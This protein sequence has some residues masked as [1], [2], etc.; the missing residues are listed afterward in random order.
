MYKGQKFRPRPLSLAITIALGL[1]VVSTSTHAQEEIEEVT[2]TGSRIV[3]RDYQASSPIVTV[4]EDFFDQVSTVGVENALNQLPQFVPSQSMFSSQDVQPSAFNTPG[5]AT[6]N[7]RGLG[8]NRN[9]VLMDG[10]RA[11]PAN[12]QLVVDINTIPSAAIQSVEVISGGASSVYGADAMGG[13]T[14]FILKKNFE[15]F[16]LNLQTSATEQ[17]G[18]EET[19]VSALIGGSFGRSGNVML[20]INVSER[21][22]IFARDRDFYVE[23]WRDVN[24][25]GGEDIPFT[26]IEFTGNLPASS[27]YESIFG[28]GIAAPGEE[29]YINPDGTVFLNSASQGAVGYSGP[30]NDQ[31]KILGPGT[32]EPGALSANWL[33]QMLSTPLKRYSMFAR[34]NYDLNDNTNVFLQTNMTQT[35]VDTVLTFAPATSQWAANIP[36]DGRPVPP[37]L[38]ALLDSRPNPQGDYILSR[39]L[40]F[41]GPRRTSNNTDVYQ[42]L[43]GIEGGIGAS[44]WSYEAYISHGKTS[45]LTEMAGFPGLQNYRSVVEAPNWGQDLNLTVGA[46]LFFELKCTTGLPMV[47]YFEP[48][49]DCLDSIAGSMKHLTEMEQDIAEVNLTGELYELPAGVVGAAFGASYRENSYRWRPDD[50]LARPSTNYPIG[51][52]PTSYTQGKT[53]VKELY[54]ELLVPVL[55]GINGIEQLNLELGARYSDFNTAGEVW[56]YKGL[57]DWTINDVA[58][59]RGGFQRANRAPNVAELFTGAT[60]SVRGFAGADPCMANTNNTTWGNHPDNPNR[61][62]V[63][64]L[65]SE[66]INR[67]TG[68]NNE[69]PWHTAPNFPDAVVGPFPFNFPIELANITG[70]ANLENEEAD[71]LTLGVVLNSPFSGALETATLSIDWY[72]VEISNAIAP[73][74]AWS[75]Y[76]KCLNEDGSN[77]N[78]TFNEYCEL[79]NRDGDGYRATV[80]T[81]YFNLG[82][83]ET[84]GVDVQFNW[85]I[86]ALGGALNINS[87][88]NFLD[89][90]RDQVGPTD[91]FTDSTG[92]L[93]SGGQFDYRTF[94]TLNYMRDSWSVGLRHRF[95]PSIDSVDSANNPNST[96]QGAGSYNM[97]DMYGSYSV[98]ERLN[99]RAGIDNLFDF[100]PEIVGRN[101]GTTEARGSTSTGYYDAIG[102]RFYLAVDV[103]F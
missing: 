80:D 22:A 82:G 25:S 53:D 66:L 18:G 34:A 47:S 46:P 27:V 52:F 3:R 48:S 5:I 38:Q 62:Q 1:P 78:Y 30:L 37:Q 11:Q 73:T 29:V 101:P 39:T 14:N 35:R 33:D 45:L 75:V 2:I 44:S 76:A 95:L 31:F 89:Y 96:V 23:G 93:R 36:V 81:P 65:C 8:S 102:R 79:I 15:G 60:T 59:V 20:G 54:G 17:G 74:D 68:G 100:D 91:P 42:L 84:A 13:V 71:T 49:Q 86:D 24:T 50:Q 51:L 94:T 63:I 88:V 103:N 40:D 28:P 90:Y 41:T 58:R 64:E 19:T 99:L 9:L 16:N 92:T 77:P 83:I 97:I 67:S 57:V 55:N 6:L 4:N 98:S 61:A 69:S 21:Q 56:T 72:Q 26:N 32:D 85:R 87:V 7:L 10:R 43:A 70:N 12:A